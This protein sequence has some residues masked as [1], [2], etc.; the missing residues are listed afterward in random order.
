MEWPGLPREMHGEVYVQLWQDWDVRDDALALAALVNMRRTC[1]TTRDREPL[2]QPLS[3]LCQDDWYAVCAALIVAGSTTRADRQYHVPIAKECGRRGLGARLREFDFFN[4]S[5]PFYMGHYE[6]ALLAAQRWTQAIAEATRE[7][8]SLEARMARGDTDVTLSAVHELKDAALFW[9]CAIRAGRL[10]LL[11]TCLEQCPT[12]ELAYI[13]N[14]TQLTEHVTG[15]TMAFLVH[16]GLWTVRE[17]RW[18]I[19][20][21]CRSC[22]V[23]L[24][25][26]FYQN[27]PA[28]EPVPPYWEQLATHRHYARAVACLEWLQRQFPRAKVTFY[29]RAKGRLYRRNPRIVLWCLAHNMCA[30]TPQ[31][32]CDAAVRDGDFPVFVALLAYPSMGGHITAPEFPSAATH[33][34]AVGDDTV[35]ESWPAFI[36]GVA[37]ACAGIVLV[38]AVINVVF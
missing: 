9:E 6:R 19:A 16:R 14:H 29:D 15:R 7:G 5:A 20:D 22:N 33:A 1:R 10:D 31:E 21:A 4:V 36:N 13:V 26:W 3:Y 2:L 32:I 12:D 17:V 35:V 30:Q 24:L 37:M 38:A 18:T 23:S 27:G 25:A 28:G 11:K 34:F 8:T